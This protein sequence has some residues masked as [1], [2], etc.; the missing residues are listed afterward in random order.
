MTWVS[1]LE[2]DGETVGEVESLALVMRGA[3]VGHVWDCA[4]SE[5]RFMMMVPLLM[6]SSIG[7]RVSPGT[8]SILNSLP[9][10]LAALANTDNDVEAVVTGVQTLSVALRA[11]ADEGEGVRF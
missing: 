6:A 10:A 7:K 2:D 1:S 5:R 3:M 11:L 8:H 9:P 4:A